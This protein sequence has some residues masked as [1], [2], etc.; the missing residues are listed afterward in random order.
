MCH[1]VAVTEIRSAQGMRSLFELLFE[2]FRQVFVDTLGRS[3]RCKKR[4]SGRSAQRCR[5]NCRPLRSPVRPP[6]IAA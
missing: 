6:G 1:R 2:E 3:P 4:K 5:K